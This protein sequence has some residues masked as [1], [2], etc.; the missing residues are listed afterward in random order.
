MQVGVFEKDPQRAAQLI[1]GWFGERA[2]E[3]AE[4]A[5]RARALAKPGA[6]LD[7]VR[8]LATLAPL[9]TGVVTPAP[10][11]LMGA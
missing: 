2:Q 10:A 4:M 5:E 7:I 3:F 1:R 9:P 6:L 8:D 11:A